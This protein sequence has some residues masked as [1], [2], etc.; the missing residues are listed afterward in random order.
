MTGWGGFA[1]RADF[2]VFGLP[3]LAK[4]KSRNDGVCVLQGQ[5]IFDSLRFKVKS[6]ILAKFLKVRIYARFSAN[7]R[8]K[9]NLKSVNAIAKL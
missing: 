2:I 1:L 7:P 6:A 4:G 5:K 8:F 3:R 9:S